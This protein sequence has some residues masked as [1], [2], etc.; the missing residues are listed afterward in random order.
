M[1][2]AAGLMKLIQRA[3]RDDCSVEEAVKL[4][5]AE[6]LVAARMVALANSAAY[7]RGGRNVTNVTDAVSL[8]GL[9]M[10]KSVACDGDEPV[11][12]PSF[13]GE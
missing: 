6:P 11:G 13:Q 1:T 8:L 2:P 9:S 12:R 7:N 3:N 4:A 5:A 10:L